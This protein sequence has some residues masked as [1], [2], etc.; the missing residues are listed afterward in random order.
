MDL[1]PHLPSD[2]NEEEP[3][4]WEGGDTNDELLM[5]Y[6]VVFLEVDKVVGV[7][8]PWHQRKDVCKCEGEF[9][10]LVLVG[11]ERIQG[12]WVPFKPLLHHR[13]TREFVPDE[14]RWTK[15]MDQKICP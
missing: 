15:K 3:R 7:T 13:S 5:L 1:V 9:K 2:F 14:N 12:E 10:Y 4:W 8:N 6:Q 11:Q